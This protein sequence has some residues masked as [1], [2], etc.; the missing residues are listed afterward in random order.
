MLPAGPARA[1]PRRRYDG[2]TTCCSSQLVSN[3]EF[4]ATIRVTARAQ[5]LAARETLV[6]DFRL[7]VLRRDDRRLEELRGRLVERRFALRRLAREEAHGHLRRRARHDLA[8]LEDRVVLVARDDQLQAR[9]RRVVAGHGRH[10]IHAGGLERGDGAARRAV[11]GRHHAHDLR[12][13]AR[14][15]A[16]HPLL[17]LGRRPLRRVVFGERLEAAAFEPFV[18]ALLDEPCRG[19]GRRTVDFEHAALRGRH[20]AFLE[21]LHERLRDRLADLLVIER[22]VVVGGRRRHRTVVSDDLDA[23]ALRHVHERGGR[24]RIDRIEHDHFRPLRD[25]RIELLLL[26]RSVGVG[27]LVKHLAVR[28]ELGH[29]GLE[30]RKVV[31][32]V[33]RGCMIGHQERDRA[34]GRG[35]RRLTDRER[36]AQ[37]GCADRE[38]RKR[39]H[40]VSPLF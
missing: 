38:V 6:D 31:L 28:T 10:G 26:L 11:V 18:N 1:A 3:T 29:L 14:D 24:R 25:H 15:L 5:I 9:E 33:T 8:G 4:L 32:L 23:L 27:V 36:G 21:M 13:E 19:I 2:S 37:Q 17:R 39:V 35:V 22:H 20:A 34:A 7:E 30:A 40:R 12:A 16:A